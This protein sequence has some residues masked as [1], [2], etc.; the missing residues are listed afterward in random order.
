MSAAESGQGGGGVLPQDEYIVSLEYII[1]KA[2]LIM[3]NQ[4]SS[5]YPIQK[6]TI[7]SWWGLRTV[8]VGCSYEEYAA[9]QIHCQGQMYVCHLLMTKVIS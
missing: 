5:S 4:I 2:A 1:S 3:A 8:Q 7:V 9:T 6:Q